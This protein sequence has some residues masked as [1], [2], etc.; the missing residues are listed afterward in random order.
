[1][2]TKVELSPMGYLGERLQILGSEMQGLGYT[3]SNMHIRLSSRIAT[4]IPAPAEFHNLAGTAAR[5]Q[6]QIEH[7]LEQT[8]AMMFAAE[9]AAPK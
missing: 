3:L 7:T 1:M 6:A 8:K 5:L 4:E 2:D 9:R